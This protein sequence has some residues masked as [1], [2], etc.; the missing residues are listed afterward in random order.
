MK[1]SLTVICLFV[2][3]LMLSACNLIRTNNDSDIS[4]TSGQEETTIKREIQYI[5]KDCTYIVALTEEKLT[6]GDAFP[7]APKKGDEYITADYRYTYIKDIYYLDELIGETEKWHVEVLDCNKSEYEP[8]MENICYEPVTSLYETFYGCRKL[9]VAPKI[10]NGVTDMDHTF[11]YCDLLEIA[12]EIPE[13][14][15]CLD[16]TFSNCDQLKE[17]PELK[18]GVLTMNGTFINCRSLKNIPNIP[19]SVTN[20]DF[21]FWG[22]D[23]LEVAP[24]IPESVT[25]MNSTFRECVNLE[26]APAIPENVTN[27]SETFSRCEKLKT[28]PETIPQ[29]VD[30]LVGTF[31]RCTSLTGEIEINTN[32]N[33]YWSCFLY[34]DFEKQNLVLSGTSDYLE[35]IKATAEK[36]D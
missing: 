35:E 27:L 1:K 33:S 2:L 24:K 26:I 3:G 31:Y 8:I 29:N 11:S 22:C 9:L 16:G 4:D 20:M 13:S 34:V 12:P 15:E 23:N 32:T 28:A 36:T 7:D 5:P 10:P 30:S 14:V 6:E 18:Y 25:S 19:S 21:T 17:V